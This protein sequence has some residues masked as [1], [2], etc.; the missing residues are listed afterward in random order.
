MNHPLPPDG[1]MCDI[2][3]LKRAAVEAIDLSSEAL[4]SLSQGIWSKPEVNFEEH[5]AHALL[6]DFLEE[7]GFT[8][9]R[10]H[11][12]STGWRAELG[13]AQRCICF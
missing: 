11:V 7:R 2:T 6:T 12:L 13:D 10:H 8:V 4:N 9:E 5:T 1:A 3:A